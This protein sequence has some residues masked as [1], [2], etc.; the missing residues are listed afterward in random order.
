MTTGGSGFGIMALIVA[1]ERG[2][3]ARDAAL[4][5][6]QRMLNFLFARP[7]TTAPSRTS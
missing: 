7:A 5:R 6:L 4:E 1:V 2:W 3:V